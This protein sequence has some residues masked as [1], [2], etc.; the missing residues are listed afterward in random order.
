MPVD[1]ELVIQYVDRVADLAVLRPGFEIV[2]DHRVRPLE[3]TAGEVWKRTTHGL[4]RLQVDS[5]NNLNVAGRRKLRYHR[6][7]RD[8]VRKL[9][10]FVRHLLRDGSATDTHKQRGSRWLHQDV[11]TYARLAAAAVVEH[12]QHDAD[13]QQNQRDF[14][15]NREDADDGANRPMHQVG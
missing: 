13:N 3:R 4:K 12:A 6:R 8:H 11:G 9:A 2:D 1:G 14:D 7:N 10:N 15:R 5:V